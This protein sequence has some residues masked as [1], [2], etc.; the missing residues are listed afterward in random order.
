[1]GGRPDGPGGGVPRPRPHS[2][3]APS[4]AGGAAPRPWSLL[5]GVSPLACFKI[6]QQGVVRF[7]RA[8]CSLPAT[9][10]RL[11]PGFI[12]LLLAGVSDRHRTARAGPGSSRCVLRPYWYLEIEGDLRCQNRLLGVGRRSEDG[13]SRSL[14]VAGEEGPPEP[15]SRVENLVNL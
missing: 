2:S 8:A 14:E 9:P 3:G 15:R 5:G 12:I 11:S 6:C 1:M 4:R 13:K 10:P 7:A